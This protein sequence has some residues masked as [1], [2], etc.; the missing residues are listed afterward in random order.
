[1]HLLQALQDSP[2]YSTVFLA[3]VHIVLQ[4]PWMLLFF[5]LPLPS[6]AVQSNVILDWDALWVAMAVVKIIL[7]G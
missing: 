6:G 4:T 1:M 3:E 7:A 2:K 5:F